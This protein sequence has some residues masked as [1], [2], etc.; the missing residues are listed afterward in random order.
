MG[1]TPPP[2]DPHQTQVQNVTFEPVRDNP[3]AVA[4]LFRAETLFYNQI[5]HTHKKVLQ[6]QSIKFPQ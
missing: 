5:T 3:K 6:T 1:V 4:G 2:L